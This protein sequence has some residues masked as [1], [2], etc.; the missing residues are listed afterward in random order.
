MLAQVTLEANYAKK[1]ATLDNKLE[2]KLGYYT[3][4]VD[5]NTKMKTNEDLLRMTTK[6][7]LKAWQSW[8][9]SAQ[10]QG[11]TQ[12]MAVYDN[13]VPTKLKSKF[14]APAY[15]NISI[16]MDYKPKFK[17]NNITLSAQLSPLSYNC[18]YVS[19][20]SIG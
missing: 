4:E 9:Y 8:Y 17:N 2:M 13:K 11:Y 5:G 14:F 6:F 3:T 15:G 19:V 7:G 12:F 20:D 18:R 16:G 10:I 1:Q